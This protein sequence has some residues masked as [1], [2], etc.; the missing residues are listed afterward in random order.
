MKDFRKDYYKFPGS[1]YFNRILDKV[2][3]I[4]ELDKKDV[5]I[6]D[7]GCGTGHLKKKLWKKSK[8]IGYDILP[9]LT[10]VNDWK[11]VK[12]DIFVANQVFCYFKSEDLRKLIIEIKEINPKT[13]LILVRSRQNML[14]KIA[15]ILAGEKDAHEGVI[16]SPKEELEILKERMNIIKKTSVFFMCD[17]YLFK[18][19]NKI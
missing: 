19:K 3:K 11:K 5:K 15:A 6:L 18:F 4:G 8:V 1:I 2:I 13:E 7:F 10:E 9:E 16:L 12:F 14:S 17:I